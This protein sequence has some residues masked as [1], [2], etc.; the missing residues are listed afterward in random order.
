[1]SE[2]TLADSRHRTKRRLTPKRSALLVI[3]VAMAMVLSFVEF[4]LIPSAPWLKYDP[5]SIIALIASLG[6]GPWWGSAVAVLA[7]A[8]R[9]VSDPL[10]SFMNIAAALA[11]VIPV[12]LAYRAEPTLKRAAMGM[13][14][15]ALCSLVLS[16]ALNFV[17]TPLYYAPA[18]VADVAR[19]IPTELLP[20]NAI[21]LA[22]NACLSLLLYRKL[23]LLVDEDDATAHDEGDEYPRTISH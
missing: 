20:F 11:I 15:G 10:G 2:N 8:P 23:A 14:L 9:L 13:V 12:G 17:I 6:F 4:P 3:L 21:K 19:S 22:V 1:M 7:W 16:I 18:T 5:S